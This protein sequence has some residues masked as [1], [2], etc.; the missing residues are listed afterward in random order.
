MKNAI[1]KKFGGPARAVAVGLIPGIA[2][3][4]FEK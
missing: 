2:S 1:S 4:I 3:L